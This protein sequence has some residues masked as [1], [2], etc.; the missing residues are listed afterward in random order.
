MNK[1]YKLF[2]FDFDGTL[3]DTKECVVASFQKSLSHNNLSIADRNKIIQLMGISLPDV[4][5]KLTHAKL[6]D[7]MYEK[8]VTDYRMFYKD[9]LVSK[10]QIFPDVAKTLKI[11][12]EKKILCSIAT[13][14][15]T[16]F[17][18]LSCKYLRID[19]YIDFYIGDDMV[20]QKKPNPEMLTVTLKKLNINK[21][22][23]VMIGDSTFDIDMGNA[24]Q[25]DT[26]AVTWG[27]HSLQLLKSANPTYTINKFSELLQFVE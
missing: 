23:A 19:T 3:G 25:M 20:T 22:D 27:S 5:R 13:S 21:L 2:I 4:F 6:D 8:L 17:A 24:I 1:K 9:F 7:A 14:K 10:T 12:K 11:L 16:E 26:I 15:K 18:I